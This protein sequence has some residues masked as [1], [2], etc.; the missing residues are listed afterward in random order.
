MMDMTKPDE[1]DE[2]ADHERLKVALRLIAEAGPDARFFW[3]TK[4]G[5]RVERQTVSDLARATLNNEIDP[6]DLAGERR[7]S[8]R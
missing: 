7:L 6:E 3:V 8:P 4:T 5:A 2:P 1:P